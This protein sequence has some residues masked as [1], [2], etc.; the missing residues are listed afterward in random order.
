MYFLLG[1]SYIVRMKM[2]IR[3]VFLLKGDYLVGSSRIRAIQ[4]FDYFSKNN[5]TFSVYRRS[6]IKSNFYG[7]VFWIRFCFACL[8]SNLVFLQKPL[9]PS[10]VISF[11]KWLNISVLVDID[12]AIWIG[13]NG[14]DVLKSKNKL[15]ENLKDIFK[16][17]RV[18]I[19]G[20]EYLKNCLQSIFFDSKIVVIRPSVFPSC[21]DLTKSRSEVVTIG[22][23][24]GAQ[25]LEELDFLIP[26][27]EKLRLISRFNFL[28]CADKVSEKFLKYAH[29]IPWTLQNEKVFFKRCD[30]GLMP[31]KSDPRSLGR[32]GFKAI[33][34][35]A[36]RIPVLASSHGVAE[37]LVVNGANGFLCGSEDEWFAALENLIN[38]YEERVSMGINGFEFVE[39]YCNGIISQ[40]TLVNLFKTI[41]R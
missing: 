15:G 5:I 27:L 36:N 39:K 3:V 19:C 22:W 34:Y 33:Q 9:L 21:I 41:S 38:S 26:I 14:V 6:D 24:G 2:A 11:L 20:S 25:N 7:F 16:M 30:I 31:L 23:I 18:I 12:D 37:E 17:S 8:K 4:Y 1:F 35:M 32:C 13:S 29:F 10:Y 40:V 28:I